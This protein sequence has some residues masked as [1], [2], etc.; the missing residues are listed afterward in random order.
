MSIAIPSLEATCHSSEW[1]VEPHW[2]NRNQRK[3]KVEKHVIEIATQ[4]TFAAS[5]TGI[6]P[7]ENSIQNT[8]LYQKFMNVMSDSITRKD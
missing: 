2:I 7:I 5:A 3:K 4:C 6:D 1:L 8:N